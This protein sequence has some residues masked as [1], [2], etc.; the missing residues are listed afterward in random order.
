VNTVERA[1]VLCD[2]EWIKPEHF[3]PSL[4]DMASVK[5]LAHE[6]I[7]AELLPPEITEEMHP[8]PR[9]TQDIHVNGPDRFFEGLTED[10]VLPLSVIE[11]RYIQ[12]VLER[13]NGVKDRA[14]KMLKVDRKTLYR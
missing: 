1:V 8:V 14:A 4:I 9:E 13:V 6:P 11:L 5:E 12:H 2:A 10:E 7:P 3:L